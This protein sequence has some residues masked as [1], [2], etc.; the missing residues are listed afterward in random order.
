MSSIIQMVDNIN[1]GIRVFIALSLGIM[2]IVIIAQVISRYFFGAAF[3]WAEEVSRY[4]MVYSV[5]LGAALAL[6]THSLIAVEV[7][8]EKISFH[9]K[10]TLKI[11]VYLL[12]IIFFSV[13]LIKGINILGNVQMQ[14]TPALQ[15]SMSI[16]Y[17]AIP[18]GAAALILNSVAVILELII[19]K[20]PPEQE[21]V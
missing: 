12:A 8:A 15:I 14:R 1:K 2:S 11:I 6:R 10:R 3:T 9:A 13:L 18:V 20:N 19:N 5:F 7:I 17:L 4:L 21:E 16:P